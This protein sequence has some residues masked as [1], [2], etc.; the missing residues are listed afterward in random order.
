MPKIVIVDDQGTGRKILEKLA[1]S[2][3]RNVSVHSFAS[4]V[5]A[6]TWASSHEPD[7]I[8]TDYKMPGMTGVEFTRALRRLPTCVD[9][10]IVVVTSFNDKD[11]RYG[12]LEAGA[13][14]FLTKPVDHVEFRARSKN[15]LKLRR[16][17]HI[18]KDR[19][20]WLEKK[21]TEATREIHTREKET[22]LRLAKAGEYRDEETGNHVLRMAKYSRLIAEQL[23]LPEHECE[24][25]DVAAPMHDIGKIG[26]S[27]TILLKPGKLSADE[28]DSMK[29]HATIG[30]EILKDSP[31]KYLQKGA[32]IAYGHHEKFDGSG[33]P[34]RLAGELIPL[35]ARIVAVADVFDALTS[36][37]P[38]KKAW[39]IQDALEYLKREQGAHFDPRLVAAFSSKI[40]DVLEICQKFSDDDQRVHL[41]TV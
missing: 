1:T 11:V 21:V 34:Q 20:A 29:D 15:L 26:V 18:I 39:P 6:L 4:P 19:A 17:Q 35:S 25:I 37:R 3:E 41:A 14:D 2:I 23:S 7:L 28:F 33:Y 40:S 32:E 13:T 38:Y 30:Y 12:A 9:V 27:D 31:S 36:E 10:P 24:L 16:Q 22:L 5:D 8:Y